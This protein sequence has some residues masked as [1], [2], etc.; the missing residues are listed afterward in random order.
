MNEGNARQQGSVGRALRLFAAAGLAAVTAVF[1]A[2]TLAQAALTG[3]QPAEWAKIV[4]AAK[5]EGKVVLYGT[6]V[7]ALLTRFKAGF[8]KANPGIVV[9]H[10]RLIGTQLVG[11]VDLER[12]TAVD[13]ADVIISPEVTWIAARAKQGAFRAPVGPAAGAWPAAYLVDGL[14]P[15][16]ALEPLVLAYNTNLIKTT[17]TGYLDLLK[18]EFKG[19]IGVVEPNAGVLVAWYDWLEKTQGADFLA[20]LAAQN[21]R[22]YVSAL[23]I[24]QGTIAGEIA[25]SNFTVPS[26][27]VPLIAQGAPL[28]MVV[29]N[30]S[31]GTPYAGAVL[32]WAKRPNA[33]LVFMDYMM[34]V[35]GQTEWAGRGEVGSPIGVPG[36]LDAKTI[37]PLDQSR[38]SPDVSNAYQAKW[39]KIFKG[40]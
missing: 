29:P 7:P 32:A 28:K 15:V 27:A 1:S 10:T 6:P 26:V 21:P 11:K 20:K 31:V 12:Q 2:P 19:K 13:G 9:E 36:S 40:Q 38:Y 4:A 8:E 5:T 24:T 16:L 33:A 35:A 17:V 25:F 18:P 22:I 34:S 30:P 23:P 39:G 3:Y 14:S 37:N